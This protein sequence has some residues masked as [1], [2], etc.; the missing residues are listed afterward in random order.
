V[1]VSSLSGLGFG[2]LLANRARLIGV[3]RG[4]SPAM[5]SPLRKAAKVR[6]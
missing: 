2:F 5:S 3:A 4:Y 6:R 1:A